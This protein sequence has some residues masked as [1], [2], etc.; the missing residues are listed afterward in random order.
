MNVRHWR[1]THTASIRIAVIY[2]CVGCL[3]ILFSATLVGFVVRDSELIQHI[4]IFKGLAFVLITAGLLY[5]LIDRHH[6]RTSAVDDRL[7]SRCA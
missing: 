6:R 4:S 7:T 2:A 3:W 5:F 1:K